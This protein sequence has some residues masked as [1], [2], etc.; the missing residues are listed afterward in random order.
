MANDHEGCPGTWETLPSPSRCRPETPAYQLRVD[1]RPR[2]PGRRGRTRDTTVVSPSEGNEARREGRQGV[3][4]P[5][6]SD[7]AGERAL[8]DP[9]ERRGCR[10]VDPRLEPR[11]GRRASSACHRE[12]EDRV[13]GQRSHGVRNRMRDMCTSGSVGDLGG[14]PPRSTR[15]A[16]RSSEKEDR[17]KRETFYRNPA[18]NQ[19]RPEELGQQPE[20]SLAR[21]RVTSPAK[22][23]QPDQTL[24]D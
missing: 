9:V 10:V 7:E 20:A 18:G 22:R 19:S 6:S 3:A 13:E 8:P 11:R 23:R 5:H 2:V 12:A 1:P 14:S 4:A 17:L 16:P 15:L 21:W 24:C